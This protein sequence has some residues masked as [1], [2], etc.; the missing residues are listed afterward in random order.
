MCATKSVVWAVAGWMWLGAHRQWCSLAFAPVNRLGRARSY[1]I[2]HATGQSTQESAIDTRYDS[3]TID[4]DAA[5]PYQDDSQKAKEI[6]YAAILR[7]IDKSHNEEANE[8]CPYLA[9]E[10]VAATHGLQDA[11]K[12]QDDATTKSYHSPAAPVLSEDAVN[13]LRS[14]ARYFFESQRESS[15]GAYGIER[16]DLDELLSTDNGADF[17]WRGEMNDALT[18]N[19][20]PL[21]RAGWPHHDAFTPGHGSPVLTVTSASVFAGGGYPGAKV[22]TTTFERDA[23]LFVVHIDLGNDDTES[24]TGALYLE[25]LADEESIVGPLSP[26]Q[27][28]VH[29]STERTAAITVP[30]NFHALRQN[31]N[32]SAVDTLSRRNVLSA[33]ESARQYCLRLVLTTK[34]DETPE[35]NAVDIPEAPAEERSYRLRS[36]ARFRDDRVR[37][38][39]LAGLLDVNDYE[40]HLWLGFD[41]IARMGNPDYQ[42][43]V[44]QRLS[45]VNKAIFHLEKA[46]N[47]CPSD[48]RIHFQLATAIGSKMDCEKRLRA[49]PTNE[50][51]GPAF[52]DEVAYQT[53]MAAALEASAHF[54][55]A[56]VRAGVS[57]TADLAIC[58]HALAETRLKLELFDEALCVIDRWAECNSIR[59]ALAIEDPNTMGKIPSYEWIQTPVDGSSGLARNVAVRTLGDVPLFDPDDVDLLRQAADKHFALAAGVQTSRY[60]MQYEGNSE[61]HLDDLCASDPH[62]RVR[63]DRILNEKVYPLVRTAFSEDEDLEEGGPPLGPLCVYD[64]IFVRYNGDVARAA[65]RIGAS[66]P[67]HQDGGIYSVNVA[68]NAHRDDDDNGFTG[69]GTFLEALTVG[70]GEHIQRPIA[71]GHAIVHKTTQRHAGAPTTSGIRDILVIFLTARRPLHV[72]NDANTWNVERAMRLQSIAKEELSR[73]KLLPSLQ[74]ARENDPVNSEVPYWLG[75]HLIQGD[76]SDPSDARWKEICRG[77]ESLQASALL[78]PADARAHYHLGMGISTRHKYAMRTKRAHL[79]PPPKEAAESLVEAF[80]TAI[81]LERKCERAGCQ[82]EINCAAAYLAL[83]DFMARLKSFDKAMPYLNQVET[84]IREAGD[85]G[86]NWARNML[87]EV[88]GMLA[89][90]EKESAKKKE[91]SFAQ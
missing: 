7:A 4:A 85:I 74:L 77:V 29:R 76:M 1:P 68:L 79:L 35:T 54:E 2:L 19:I 53:K 87:E 70:D 90:C 56:A 44:R 31:D 15:N 67:L 37:F 33:A 45:D 17:G 61:V 52:P 28:A 80:E 82:N 12:N 66:Q 65:G 38:L 89:Y 21:V 18:Q 43:D 55:S 6:S 26:G 72:E 73:E 11:A 32:R 40:N 14:S 50:V 23:G 88:D 46:A 64:S 30:S 59:S 62:L 13:A 83:G 81:Q 63:I 10:H 34:I 84:T 69:G 58:Y 57:G 16:V 60:T 39:T 8:L 75:V 25:S 27:V 48:A 51:N 78:N 49:E 22:A 36:Y 42:N 3:S 24:A 20:Y 91:T 47:L 5:T 9:T 41:Y 71:P 86:E